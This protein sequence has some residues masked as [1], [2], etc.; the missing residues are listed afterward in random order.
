M[1]SFGTNAYV[2]GRFGELVILVLLFA[3]A[4]AWRPVTSVGWIF[5]GSSAGDDEKS[6]T[7]PLKCKATVGAPTGSPKHHGIYISRD[8][9][10][11][12][13]QNPLLSLDRNVNLSVSQLP[14]F[15]RRG[16]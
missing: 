9:P 4:F 15:Y 6:P 3:V 11:D 7:S 1:D 10:C 2:N 5:R 8:A 14:Y 13:R 16:E 12:K